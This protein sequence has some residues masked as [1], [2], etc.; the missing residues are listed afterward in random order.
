MGVF[1]VGVF[2]IPERGYS[3][4]H[5]YI[6]PGKVSLIFE[7]FFPG[8]VLYFSVLKQCTEAVAQRCSFKKEFFGKI[9]RKTPVPESLF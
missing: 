3:S 9:H 6:G 4:E 5:L 7:K 1:R 8:K 2:L